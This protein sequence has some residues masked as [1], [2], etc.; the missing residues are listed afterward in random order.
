M[1]DAAKLS[2]YQRIVLLEIIS[3]KEFTENA[4][5]DNSLQVELFKHSVSERLRYAIFSSLWT[6]TC[7]AIPVLLESE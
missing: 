4:I 7:A 5:A 2:V 3:L 1:Q 6:F